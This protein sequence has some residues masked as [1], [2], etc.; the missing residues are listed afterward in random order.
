MPVSSIA[1]RRNA[2]VLRRNKREFTEAYEEVGKAVEL[3][4]RAHFRLEGIDKKVLGIRSELS[5]PIR[6]LLDS[7]RDAAQ[8]A[9]TFLAQ[10]TQDLTKEQPNEV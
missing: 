6:I 1:N 9:L 4:E 8:G 5:Y 3:L 2:R 10:A 7:A